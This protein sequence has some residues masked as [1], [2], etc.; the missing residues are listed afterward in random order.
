MPVN[1]TAISYMDNPLDT[2]KQAQRESILEVLSELGLTG[3]VRSGNSQ[4]REIVLKVD[5]RELGRVM[6]DEG[7]LQLMSAGKNMFMLGTA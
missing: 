3:A 2:I 5:R 7:S 1:G 4:P 6:I